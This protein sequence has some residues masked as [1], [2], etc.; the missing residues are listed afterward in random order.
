MTI[1]VISS[2]HPD[3][4][5]F[6]EESKNAKVIET[7]VTKAG[8]FLWTIKGQERFNNKKKRKKL[9]ILLIIGMLLLL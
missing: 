5:K 4:T 1:S 7:I 3:Y 6:L 2:R 8:P 9:N